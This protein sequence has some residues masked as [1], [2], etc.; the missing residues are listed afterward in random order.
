[1]N[2][3]MKC[4]CATDP[5]LIGVKICHFYWISSF[6]QVKILSS[7]SQFLF[8]WAKEQFWC[9]YTAEFSFSLSHASNSARFTYHKPVNIPPSGPGVNSRGKCWFSPLGIHLTYTTWGMLGHTGCQSTSETWLRLSGL[10]GH[11][12]PHIKISQ[13]PQDLNKQ[14]SFSTWR[15]TSKTL[16]MGSRLRKAMSPSLA[17]V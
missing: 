5:G 8:F 1:M 10:L 3:P 2:L 15:V 14:N 11:M 16:L 9:D 6:G 4:H 17:Y 13:C 7:F 12:I